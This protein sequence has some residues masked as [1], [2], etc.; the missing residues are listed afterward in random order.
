LRRQPHTHLH[1]LRLLPLHLLLRPAQTQLQALVGVVVCRVD[2]QGG[3]VRLGGSS[4]VARL[5]RPVFV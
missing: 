5:E 3:G 1:S 4:K 2:G